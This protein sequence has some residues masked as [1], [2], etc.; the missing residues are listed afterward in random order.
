MAGTR[1]G[2][3]PASAVRWRREAST[4]HS[5]EGG[6][7]TVDAFPFTLQDHGPRHPRRV[8]TTRGPGNTRKNCETRGAARGWCRFLEVVARDL[9]SLWLS[10]GGTADARR[11]L[12]SHIRLVTPK[13]QRCPKAR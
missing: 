2:G 9:S 1:P 13:G 6:A 8:A 12:S 5:H 10:I 7:D 11:D 4:D 3:R